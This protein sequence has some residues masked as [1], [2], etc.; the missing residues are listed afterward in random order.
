[1]IDRLSERPPARLDREVQSGL[2]HPGR[3][4]RVASG[5]PIL[6]VNEPI[7]RGDDL[8]CR[9]NMIRFYRYCRDKTAAV[10][11][12]LRHLRISGPDIDQNVSPG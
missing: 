6:Q 1:M 8:A 11:G 7:H 4:S 5:R 12:K 9:E 3:P 10:F 2:Q